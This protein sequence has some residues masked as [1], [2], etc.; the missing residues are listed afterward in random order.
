MSLARLA[1]KNSLCLL[2]FFCWP[3]AWHPATNRAPQHAEPSQGCRWL[4]AALQESRHAEQKQCQRVAG[5]RKSWPSCCRSHWASSREHAG[6]PAPA[7]HP[8]G[9]PEGAGC[10]SGGPGKRLAGVFSF[11]VNWPGEGMPSC[12]IPAAA[13]FPASTHGSTSG[14]MRT[15]ILQAVEAFWADVVAGRAC[16]SDIGA[17]P[18]KGYTL[19]EPRGQDTES[20]A[21]PGPAPG[22]QQA[23]AGTDTD[24]SLK[25]IKSS[26]GGPNGRVRRTYKVRKHAFSLKDPSAVCSS[27]PEHVTSAH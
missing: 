13:P 25:K 23:A 24:G 17:A 18:A 11:A 20:S 16:L 3:A 9:Q 26:K 2:A 1:L 22:S 12:V 19:L 6:W 5:Y 27:E 14:L 21:I 7:C 10:I 8:S 4:E 15:C